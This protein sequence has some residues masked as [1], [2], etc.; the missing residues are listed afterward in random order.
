M[1]EQSPS[2]ENRGIVEEASVIADRM[3]SG[4]SK[5]RLAAMRSNPKADFTISDI[6]MVASNVGLRSHTKVPGS[7]R[8]FSSEHVDA[9]ILTVPSRRPIKPHYVRQFVRLCDQHLAAEDAG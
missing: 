9:Y 1:A 2:P 8:G 3:L 7:H 4:R 5:K 6:E